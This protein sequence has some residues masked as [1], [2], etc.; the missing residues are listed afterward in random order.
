MI[1]LARSG[2]IRDYTTG[3]VGRQ[4]L[5]FSI[6]FMLSNALQVLYSIVDM[7]VVGQVLGSAGLSAVSTSAQVV[8]FMTLLC[9]GFSTG[10]QVR[11]SQLIGADRRKA[12]SGS[13]GTLFTLTAAIALIM[14][15]LG[16]FFARP[17]VELLQTPPESFGLAVQ[18]LVIS[19][20]GMLFSYGYNTAAAVLRGMGNSRQPCIS[21]VMAAVVNFLLDL[22]FV[23]RLNWGVAG[24]AAATVIGQTVAFAWVMRYLFR[25]R[26]EFGFDFRVGSFF[27]EPEAARAL[28]RLGIPFALR[29]AAVNISMMFVTGLVNSVSVEASAVFG[30]GLKVDEIARQVSLGVTYAV[31]TMAGQNIAA[32]EYVRTK[33]VVYW[34]WLYSFLIYLVFLFAYLRGVRPLFGLFTSDEGVLALA[35]VY[36][37]AILWSFPAMII[38]R[39]TNGFVQGIGNSG[40]SLVFAILDGFVLRIGLSWLLGIVWDLGLFGF[41]L[42][43]GL[44][45]YGTAIPGMIYL[46]GGRWKKRRLHI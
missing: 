23:V 34:G 4:L 30:V 20:L 17:V 45:T 31:S 3:P 2:L 33:R 7:I 15:A 19:S 6:P 28:T 13:V 24:A 42:G 37:A 8:N 10:G 41:F 12:L 43:Y 22:L 38:M 5:V 46:W 44:A 36:V 40:L 18:Y 26:R 25:H 1:S 14:T 16:L 21:L 11:L 35:L 27:P 9:V 32:R 39:G 29:S